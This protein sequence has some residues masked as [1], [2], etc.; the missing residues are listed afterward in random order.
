MKNIKFIISVFIF[1]ITISNLVAQD[2]ITQCPLSQF[3]PG[4]YSP[5]NVTGGMW[6]LHRTD[7]NNAPAFATLRVLLVF[8]QFADEIIEANYWP[9]GDTPVYKNDLLAL[10]KDTVG[11]YWDRYSDSTET[12]SDWYQEVSKGLMHVTGRAYSII[13]DSNALYYRNAGMRVMNQEIFNKLDAAGVDWQE[14][15]KWSGSNGNFYYAEDDYI[16]MIIKVHRTKIR[17]SLFVAN[18]PGVACL[19]PEPYSG[20]DIPVGDGKKINDGFNSLGSG[21]TIVGTA[22]GPLDKA[23]VFNIAKHEYGHYWFGA[24]HTGAGVGIMGG[25]DIYLGLWESIKLGYLD[26]TIVNFNTATYQLGDISSRS[27]NGEILQVPI[28]GYTE[29]FLISNRRKVSLYDRTMLGDTTKGIWDRI[30]SNN[31]YGKGI[32]VYHHNHNFEYQGSNDLECSDGL[33]NW[34]YKGQSYPDWSNEQLVNVYERTS[35]PSQLYNDISNGGL[36]NVDGRSCTEVWFGI[37]KRHSV[38]NGE[39]I[40]RIYTNDEDYWTSRELNGDRWDAWNVGYNEIFSP[41]SNPSTIEW[42]NNSQSGIFIWYESLNGNTANLKIYCA[43]EF[44]GNQPLDSILKWTPP[45]K[46]MGLNVDVT[47][48]IDN[49]RY[50]VLTWNHNTEPDMLQSGMRPQKR[51]KIYRAWEEIQNVPV[52]YEEIADVLIDAS[53]N[54]AEFIDYDTYAQCDNGTPEENYRLRYKVRAVDIYEDTS[55]YSDFAAIS[56]YYLNRGGEGGDGIH[57]NISFQLSQN[58]PNPFNP[59]T[60][61]Q[62]DLPKEGLVTLK[63]Y[64]VLGR[65]VKNIVNEFKPAGSYIVSFD[66][67]ELSSGIYFYR[68]EAGDFIQVKRMILIR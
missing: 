47:D 35:I 11:N 49:R 61:I 40:D 10:V 56:T 18:A 68:L 48:C 28:N 12:L 25:G 15:D 21:V 14:Y 27:S 7:E 62:F 13:L 3:T 44:G 26:R 30:L 1:M 55:V 57:S 42:Y 45:S 2:Y 46:P 20:I 58:Y 32:Y 51:Y 5:N 63:V 60:N 65:E 33:W 19:G 43:T 16:D 59:V 54:Y 17:D 6:K 37:G 4:Y 23:R 52:N 39:A 64:D 9:I 66:G 29:Y 53:T 8:V 36:E 34:T 31:D 41:Y 38:L 24:G 22:G 67:S 50:P